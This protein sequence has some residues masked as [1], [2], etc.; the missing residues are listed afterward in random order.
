[1]FLLGKEVMLYEL[2]EENL[3]S[4]LVIGT[5]FAATVGQTVNIDLVLFTFLVSEPK[6][7]CSQYYCNNNVNKFF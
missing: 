7:C 6:N 5:Y 2:N 1:M 3:A 4:E